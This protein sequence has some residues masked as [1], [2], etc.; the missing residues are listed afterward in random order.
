MS[1]YLNNGKSK[2][3][4]REKAGSWIQQDGTHIQE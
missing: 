2:S 1:G 4:Q 3:I